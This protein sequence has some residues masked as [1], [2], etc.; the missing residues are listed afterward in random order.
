[1]RSQRT[2][3]VNDDDD[4]EGRDD[5]IE[6]TRLPGGRE[7]RISRW[8]SVPTSRQS[9]RE[10]RNGQVRNGDLLE[11]G[12][13]ERDA[14]ARAAAGQAAG[15]EA[16][17]PEPALAAAYPTAGVP[18]VKTS[19][20][21]GKRIGPRVPGRCVRAFVRAIVRAHVR[22]GRGRWGGPMQGWHLGIGPGQPL[23]T[24]A[25]EARPR[26]RICCSGLCGQ[27]SSCRRVHRVDVV[28]LELGHDGHRSKRLEADEQVHRLGE[29]D[30]DVLSNAHCASAGSAGRHVEA[31]DHVDVL[32]GLVAGVVVVVVGDVEHGHCTCWSMLE[33]SVRRPCAGCW[34][35]MMIGAP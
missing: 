24:L 1:M 14:Y 9:R 19:G 28:V 11:D 29:V 17:P 8:M 2:L 20:H 21:L 34:T 12:S 3:D 16:G 31:N 23:F 7:T 32:D 10:V 27:C 6:G 22:A 4:D 15:L 25:G 30:R 33:T 18:G 13:E 5:P 35:R 26:S